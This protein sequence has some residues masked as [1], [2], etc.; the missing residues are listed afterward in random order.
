LKWYRRG[1]DA[2]DEESMVSLS[3][4]YAAGF[5]VEK[6][7]TTAVAWLR[8]AAAAGYSPAIEILKRRYS[9]D[10]SA[11]PQKSP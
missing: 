2:G 8:K 3:A 1:A 6:N 10:R 7:E 11:P 9:E 5:G 4:M